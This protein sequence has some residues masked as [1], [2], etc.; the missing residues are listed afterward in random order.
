MRL[1]AVA[2]L[3]LTLASPV[4]AQ[5]DSVANEVVAVSAPE[6][7]AVRLSPPAST[8]SAGDDSFFQSLGRDYRTFFTSTDTAR[9]LV[10][11]GAGA[12]SVSSWDV[13]ATRSAHAAWSD[14]VFGPG[15]LAGGWMEQMAFAGG[16]YAVGRMS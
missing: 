10:V 6:A 9:T 13:Q 5:T 7:E 16:V 1:P 12:A 11:F 4:A 3:L 15:R 8:S 2:V 14:D